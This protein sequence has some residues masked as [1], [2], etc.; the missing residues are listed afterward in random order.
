M[1]N[2]IVHLGYVA[3]FLVTALSA[4]GIPAGSELAMAFGG[5]LASG[6]VLSGPH[7]HFSLGVVI[8][9]AVLGE[10]VG[11]SF[12]YALGRFGGRALVD[13]AGRYLLLTHRDLDRAEA[14]LAR[15]GDSFVLIG[16][17]MPLLRSFV[18]IV[19]G[20]AEMGI[21]R[22]AIFTIVG[23]ALFT[24]AVVGLGDALGTSWHSAVK[25]FS[26]AGYVAGAIAVVAMGFGIAHRVKALRAERTE[27]GELEPELEG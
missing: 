6:K 23:S 19:A 16:R 20:L 13:K 11:S 15:R 4:F 21:A 1:Q 9:I 2:L 24:S 26:D 3:L 18:S 10:V 12:G 8:V 27:A 17:L 7:D 14:F 25:D 5:A 22:F